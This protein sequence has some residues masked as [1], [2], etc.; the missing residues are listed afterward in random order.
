VILLAL[1]DSAD[2]MVLSLADDFD[3]LEAQYPGIFGPN[4]RNSR[5]YSISS[6]SCVLGT[7]LGSLLSGGEHVL[8]HLPVL[9]GIAP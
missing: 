4:G 9:L 7:F 2:Q 1:P 6:M 3:E 8:F 5:V